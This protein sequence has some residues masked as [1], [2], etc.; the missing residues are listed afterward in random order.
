MCD[1]ACQ[2]NKISGAPGY[3]LMLIFCVRDEGHEQ[4]TYVSLTGIAVSH[5]NLAFCFKG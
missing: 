1:A 2:V 4:D 5:I 3:L